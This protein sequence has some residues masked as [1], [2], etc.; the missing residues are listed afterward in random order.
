[1]KINGFFTALLIF[2]LSACGGR[3]QDSDRQQTPQP[4]STR[5]ATAEIHPGKKVYDMACLACHMADGS[6]VP[7]MYPPLIQTEWVL[8]DKERLI[9]ITLEGLSGPIE[10]K[11]IKYNNIMPPNKHLSDQ[12]IADV[13]TFIRQSFGNNASEITP[14]EVNRVRADL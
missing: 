9:R 5:S 13:L 14:E 12:Q 11:G 10:V 7:G 3:E 4:A 8:E 6:G 1:M 2:V